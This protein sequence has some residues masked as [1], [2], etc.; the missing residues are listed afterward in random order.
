MGLHKCSCA[1]GCQREDLDYPGVCWPC[2]SSARDNGGVCNREKLK[3]RPADGIKDVREQAVGPQRRLENEARLDAYDKL[4]RAVVAGEDA[5]E[6][7]RAML[8][9]DLAEGVL[10]ASSQVRTWKLVADERAATIARLEQQ[11]I[12]LRYEK[13]VAMGQAP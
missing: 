4:A 8:V 1:C 5:S 13:E 12:D 9:S 2:W 3:P 11:T 6:E 7:T 10:F